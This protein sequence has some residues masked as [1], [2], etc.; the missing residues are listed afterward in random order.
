MKKRD[1]L[2]FSRKL[3]IV[4]VGAFLILASSP[5]SWAAVWKKTNKYGPASRSGHAMAFDIANKVAL[6]H[7]GS[8]SSGG[9]LYDLWKWDGSKWTEI[10]GYP[11]PGDRSDHA[12]AYDANRKKTVFFGGWKSG[13]GNPY[14]D[15]TWE[16]NGVAW[17]EI[18]KTGP[19][20]REKHAM[21]YDSKRKRV[22][23]FG[24][25]D[26]NKRLNDT[27]AYTAGGWKKLVESGPPGLLRHAMAYDAKR[28]RIV[29]F[30]GYSNS[31]Y[32]GDTW[33]WNGTKWTKSAAKGPSA[34]TGAFMCYDAKNGVV[35]LFGGE[36]GGWP[37]YKYC[38]DTWIWN[39]SKWTELKISGP[40]SRSDHRMVYDP[41]AGKI[42]LFGGDDPKSWSALNDS[43]TFTYK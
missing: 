22:V 4:L 12:M 3:S 21:V 14:K 36:Y 23:L 43:W 13:W 29:L 8:P 41:A 31:G 11:R 28:N 25:Y 17:K 24:G 1:R 32:N 34:R 27:W 35:L 26:G 2:F 19:S 7:G 15:D 33:L 38:K 37:S 42:I 6:V 9:E 5:V 40:S 39:G 10:T 30:G 20:G 16:W 18:E